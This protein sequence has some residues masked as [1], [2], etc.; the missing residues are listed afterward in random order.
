MYKKKVYKQ[1][2]TK[3]L[4]IHKNNKKI[5]IKIIKW[6]NSATALTTSKECLAFKKFSENKK[7]TTNK[8]I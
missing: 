3:Q 5:A 1:Q 2:S 6:M 8:Q 7:K 4:V